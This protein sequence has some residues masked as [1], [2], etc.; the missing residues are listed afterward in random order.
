MRRSSILDG[1]EIKKK[2]RK[3]MGEYEEDTT[4]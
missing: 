2:D 4:E 1:E 3:E